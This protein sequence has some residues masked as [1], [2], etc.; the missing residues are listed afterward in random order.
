LKIGIPRGLTYY[1]YYP[2]W[3][4]FFNDLGIEVVLSDKTTKQIVSAGSALVVTETCLPVKV[5]IGHVLN[6]L[7]KG[8]DIIYCPSIQS[9]EHK[10]YNCSKIRGLPDLI[11][12]VIR[13]NYLL[14]EPTFDMSEKGQSFEECLYQSVVP[15]GIKDK[16]KVKKAIGK[17][18]ETQALY[19]K[20]LHYGLEAN[21]AIQYAI[22]GKE[23]FI[24]KNPLDENKINVALISHGYNIYDEHISMK[25]IQK[26]RKMG[27]NVYFAGELSKDEA[28]Q[29]FA[30]LD[31]TLYWANEYEMTGAAGYYM[32]V[33]EIDGLITITSFGCGPDSIMIER[34]TRYSK[35][36]KKP[37]LNLTIDEHT[38]EA[39]FITRLEAFTDMI[40]RTKR[41]KKKKLLNKI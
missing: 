32:D 23:E 22:E 26:L 24:T 37:L 17:G 5:Y 11:R 10:I 30:N 34:M 8:L 20:M 14:I 38:G 4:A 9:I 35:K 18:H 39:G 40:F 41:A 7:D 6:L 16:K 31:T 36:F 33:P 21:K 27:A 3:H 2:F 13:R 19:E 29:G 12:N 28:R 25:V 1:T 15:L